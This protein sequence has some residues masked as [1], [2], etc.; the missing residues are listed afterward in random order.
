M[1]QR[2]HSAGAAHSP[3]V[4]KYCQF[5]SPTL[6]AQLE[7]TFIEFQPASVELQPTTLE[8]RPTPVQLR[9]TSGREPASGQRG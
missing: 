2:Q 3:I 8:L 1:S 6:L 7:L 9:P 5:D 4:S